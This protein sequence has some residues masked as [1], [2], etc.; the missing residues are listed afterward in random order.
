[1]TREHWVGF[2]MGAL[3]E[4]E[5]DLVEQHIADDPRAADELDRLRSHLD[6][7]SDG[8]DEAAAPVGLA[9]R[10]CAILD[11]PN[12]F[13]EVLNAAAPEKDNAPA[14]K[15]REAFDSIGGGRTAFTF[16]DMLVAVGACVAAVAIFFPALASSRLLATQLQCENNLHQVSLAL[17][18]FAGNNPNHRYPAISLS[19][20]MSVAGSYAPKLI[21]SGYIQHPETL[22]CAVE[23]SNLATQPIPTIE[24]LE[25]A[26][27]EEVEKL[28]QSLSNVLNYTMGSLVDGKLLAPV[29]QGRGDFPVSSDVVL[30]EDGK[31]I[32]QGHPDGRSNVL[33]DDGH[34]EY[35]AIDDIP[36]SM[37]QYFLNDDGQVAAGVNEEDAVVANGIAHPV[38]LPQREQAP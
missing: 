12:L 4:N 33:F 34:V 25:N 9:S 6:L 29:M 19:G 35:L 7:L 18:Q 24:Q 1:M 5:R 17:Q 11:N 13:A 15:R 31:I 38:Q 26:S 32:P 20:P 28:Q 22:R 10:T 8:L 2:L 36:E 3:D 16:M 30:L 14:P 27:P 21:D 37:R 23:K